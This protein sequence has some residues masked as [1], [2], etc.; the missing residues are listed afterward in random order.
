MTEFT[1]LCVFFTEYLTSVFSPAKIFYKIQVF[2]K[3]IWLI[4]NKI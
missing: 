4:E 1:V 2:S 3:E